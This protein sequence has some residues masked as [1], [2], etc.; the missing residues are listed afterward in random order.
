MNPLEMAFLREC[1]DWHKKPYFYFKDKYALDLLARCAG[2]GTKINALKGSPWGFLL[3]KPLV[4]AV[5]AALSGNCLSAETLSACWPGPVLAFTLE[6]SQWGTYRKYRHDTWEQTSRPG[7]NL[8]LQLNFGQHHNV[9]YR[10]LMQPWDHYHPFVTDCHPVNTEKDFTLAWARLDLDLETGE[11]LVE[12]IQTDWLRDANRMYNRVTRLFSE[13]KEQ[14]KN[15]WLFYSRERSYGD[16]RQYHEKVLQPYAE[17]WDE[18]MLAAVLGFVR[19]ELGIRRVY[20]HTFESGNR[21]KGITDTLPPRSL[22]TKLP[23]RFGFRE[24]STAPQFIRNTPYLKKKQAE[25]AG[26]TWFVLDLP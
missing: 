26:L 17:I 15:H 18:A 5:T 4:K 3:N 25:I 9:Q 16:F 21:M 8:V 6:L 22:Y 7:L 19:Q 14:I 20:Y 11:V 1:L 24:T 23:R 2:A 13:S 12:E 10:Q